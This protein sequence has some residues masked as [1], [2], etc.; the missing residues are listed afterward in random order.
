MVQCTS[1]EDRLYVLATV[2][3]QK[4]ITPNGSTYMSV[5]QAVCCGKF[6]LTKAKARELASTLTSAYKQDHWAEI[7]GEITVETDQHRLNKIEDCIIKAPS[8]GKYTIKQEAKMLYQIAQKDTFNGVGRLQLAEV[9]Y[10]LGALTADQIIGVWQATYPDKTIEQQGNIFLI[11][12][13]GKEEVRNQR[14][15]LA[16]SVPKSLV[17]A[18]SKD[19]YV[20]PEL[21]KDCEPANKPSDNIICGEV[22]V[23]DSGVVADEEDPQEV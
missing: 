2:C 23:D 8:K 7:L 10:E 22:S 18:A 14:N 4:G 20:E 5:I 21:E 6:L 9:Q 1:R 15:N 17:M 13:Q 16:P 12:W 3:K 19:Y 11:Y